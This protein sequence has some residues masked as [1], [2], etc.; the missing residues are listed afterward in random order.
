MQTLL[1]AVSAISSLAAAALCVVVI[2]MLRDERRRSDARVEALVAMA[3]AQ[4]GDPAE[5]AGTPATMAS[6]APPDPAGPLTASAHAAGLERGVGEEEP[7]RADLL[8]EPGDRW[9][10]AGVTG[11][12]FETPVTASSWRSRLAAAAA[13]AL[14]VIASALAFTWRGSGG[15]AAGAP[16]AASQPPIELLTLS[17]EVGGDSLTITGLVHNPRG[18]RPLADVSAVAFLLDDTGQTLATGDALLD[19]RR[20]EA[21]ADSPFVVKVA[22]P[23]RVNRYRI[24]FRDAAGAVIAHVDRRQTAPLARRD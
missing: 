15:P 22:M 20:L 10:Q 1:I 5:G 11:T 9:R 4:D 7:D 21:G 16:A 8:M 13:V 19:F 17:H 18:G 2:R 6:P 23:G 14:L 3:D 12:L 24:G